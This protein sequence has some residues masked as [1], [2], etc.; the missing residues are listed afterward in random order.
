MQMIGEHD[1]GIDMEGPFAPHGNKGGAQGVNMF[2]QQTTVAFQEG[3]REKVGTAG[4]ISA[5][6]MRHSGEFAAFTA[7]SK[8]K[9]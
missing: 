2:R 1:D 6:V 5:D 7:R 9:T 3:A 8:G 4:D